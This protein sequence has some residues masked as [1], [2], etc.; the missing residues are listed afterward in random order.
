MEKSAWLYKYTKGH[1]HIHA[2]RTLN[3]FHPLGVAR[4][5]PQDCSDGKAKVVAMQKAAAQ[6]CI[7]SGPGGGNEDSHEVIAE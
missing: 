7:R 5:G 4:A 3:G 6:A 1:T 2:D